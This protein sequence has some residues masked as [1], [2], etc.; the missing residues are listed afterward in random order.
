[1]KLASLSPENRFLTA[2]GYSLAFPCFGASLNMYQVGMARDLH[3]GEREREQSGW[4][5]S[6]FISSLV[7]TLD[8]LHHLDATNNMFQMAP[9]LVDRGALRKGSIRK[10]PC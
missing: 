9:N 2:S 3:L 4:A 6:Q 8:S 10:V 7:A 5:S 1:L